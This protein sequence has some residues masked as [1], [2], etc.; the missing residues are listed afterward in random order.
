[1]PEWLKVCINLRRFTKLTSTEAYAVLVRIQPES[2]FNFIL[3]KKKDLIRK[4]YYKQI[5]LLKRKNKMKIKNSIKVLAER[6]NHKVR[7]EKNCL[8]LTNNINKIELQEQKYSYTVKY[9]TD[10]EFLTIESEKAL[11]FDTLIQ[12]FTRYTSYAITIQEKELLEL[13]DYLSE[14]GKRAQKDWDNFTK[15][16][17]IA[18]EDNYIFFGNRIELEYFK[19]IYILRDD[20]NLK[21]SNCF[22]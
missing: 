8:L 13:K 18:A 16:Q 9:N 7:Y 4:F 15:K 22:V 1:M 5:I 21:A 3:E 17:K 10:K 11:I 14:E 6:Y 19:G 2:F 12:L 20:L